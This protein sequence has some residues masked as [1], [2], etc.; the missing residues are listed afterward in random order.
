[1]PLTLWPTLQENLA[2]CPLEPK[3]MNLTLLMALTPRSCAPSWCNVNSISKTVLV[4]SRRTT[5]K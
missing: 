4:H 2:P 3:C 5:Q 1:M